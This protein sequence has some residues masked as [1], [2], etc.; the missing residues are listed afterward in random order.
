M[1]Q[2]PHYHIDGLVAAE[3]ISRGVGSQAWRRTVRGLDGWISKGHERQ[4]TYPDPVH[5]D[6]E[7]LLAHAE[8]EIERELSMAQAYA[9]MTEAVL[10]RLRQRDEDEAKGQWLAARQMGR[11][12]G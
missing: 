12:R 10:N 3:S 6:E 7:S 4:D 2:V 8:I 5:P 9:A 1:P 11:G